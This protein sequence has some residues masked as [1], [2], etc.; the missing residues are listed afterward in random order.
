MLGILL[1]NIRSPESK[2]SK[3]TAVIGKRVVIV[4]RK[5]GRVIVMSARRSGG[6]SRRARGSGRR[7]LKLK[8]E[9]VGIA[10]AHLPPNLVGDL[11][12]ILLLV[13]QERLNFLVRE[14]HLDLPFFSS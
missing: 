6:S 3:H 11:A 2:K 13:D 1:I 10:N 8:R 7:S 5:D 4:R 9:L 12:N 14:L